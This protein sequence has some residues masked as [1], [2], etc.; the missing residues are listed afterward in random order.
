MDERFHP[1]VRPSNIKTSFDRGKRNVRYCLSI[2]T[3]F[4][5]SCVKWS[6]ITSKNELHQVI[7]FFVLGMTWLIKDCMLLDYPDSFASSIY[8]W[9]LGTPRV[10]L[11]NTPLHH[12]C[13]WGW[14]KSKNSFEGYW[15]CNTRPN[16]ICSGYFNFYKNEGKQLLDQITTL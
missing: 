4:Y 13:G 14:K 2:F 10:G 6:R 9:R 11:Q 8:I 15:S 1:G 5:K 7:V 3:N 16:F 12:N